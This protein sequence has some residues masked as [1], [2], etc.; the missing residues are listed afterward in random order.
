METTL[1][2]IAVCRT[3]GAC[4]EAADID[5]SRCDGL[6]LDLEIDRHGEAA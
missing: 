6:R 3:C 2:D 1:K 5:C 4:V